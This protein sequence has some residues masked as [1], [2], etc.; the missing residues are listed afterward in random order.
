L[1]GSKDMENHTLHRSLNLEVLIYFEITEM[2][3]PL[4][5]IPKMPFP[6]ISEPNDFSKEEEFEL[7]SEDM[8]G[9]NNHEE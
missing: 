9:N 5:L 2:Q 7:D 3:E 6:N 8:E 4:Y 1:V